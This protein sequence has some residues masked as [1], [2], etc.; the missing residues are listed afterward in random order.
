MEL[1]FGTV[2]TGQLVSLPVK[3]AASCLDDVTLSSSLYGVVFFSTDASHE[4]QL[5]EAKDECQIFFRPD[6]P[7]TQEKYI[8]VKL[9]GHPRLELD[10]TI[11]ANVILLPKVEHLG[12]ALSN[13]KKY[14]SQMMTS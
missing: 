3:V 7:G 6:R 2:Y 1:D 4:V 5:D 9:R 8:Q 10:L 14:F 11:K 13:D 12:M